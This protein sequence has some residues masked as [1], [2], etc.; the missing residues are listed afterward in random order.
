MKKHYMVAAVRASIA[1]FFIIILSFQNGSAQNCPPNN[2]MP[3]FE[4]FT[5]TQ[6]NSWNTSAYQSW[7][8]HK[9]D[10]PEAADYMRFRMLVPNG[11]NRCNNDGQKYPLIVFLHGSGES[12]PYD[13]NLNSGTEQNND[14]QLV[15]GGQQHRDAVANGTFPGFVIFPQIR[16][17][18]NNNNYWGIDNLHA[19]KYIIDKLI[20]DFKVDPD[21]VYMHGL[22]MGGEGT[23]I[24]LQN[25]PQTI[26]A[27]HPMSAA[28]SNFWNGATANR[29]TYRHIPLRHAQGGLDN[30]PTK[31]QGNEQVQKIREVGGNIRYD[32]FPT[33]GHGTWNSEYAKSDF[34]SW[35]LARRKN[36]IT[37]LGERT[38]FCPGEPFSVTLGLTAGFANYE[39]TKDNTANTPFASGPG[40]NEVTITDVVAAG[41]GVGT[42][43]ARFQ[44]ANGTWTAWSAGIVITT[45]QGP[46]ATPSI[47]SNGQ[48]VNLP[49]LDGSP[50]VTLTGT[51]NKTGYTW[52]RDVTALPNSTQSITVGTAGS[53]TLRSR[54]LPA[55]GFE[56]DGVTPTEFIGNP[57]GC[58]SSS[59]APVVVT[60]Q[61]GLGV[62]ATPTNFFASSTSPTSVTINW[63]DR[64]NNELGFEL[65]RSVISG[66]SYELVT[67]IPAKT[68]SNPQSYIDNN[69]S[70]N[71]T[72][73]YRMRA[74]NNSG[75]SAYT[76]QVQVTTTLDNQAPTAPV[77]TVG[78]TSRSEI[79]LSWTGATDNVGIFEYDLYQNNI[80]IA[81]TTTTSYKVTNLIAF[82]T[83]SYIVK[84]RDFVGNVSPPSNQVN[85]AAVN[86][87]LFYSYY[88]HP[89]NLSTVD[90]I[91]TS[92]TLIKTGYIAQF[93]LDP[94]TQ[95]DGFAFIYEGF[96]NIPT[97]GSYTFYTSSDD[98][99][100]LYVNN[101]L[102]V[103]N[104]GTHGCSE[105]ASSVISLSAGTYPV[106]AMMF[107][108]GGGECLTVSWQGPGISKAEIPASALR[109]N[110]TPP[111]AL[112]TPNNFSASAASF[113]QINISWSD[114][115]NNETG[116]E[117]SRSSSTNGTYQVIAVTAA[118]ATSYQHTG[119]SPSS[120][121]YY[122]IR[123]INATSASALVGPVNAT[124][125]NGP[126]S[127]SAPS[128][129]NATAPSPTQVNLTW[130][131]NSTSETGYEIQKSSSSS[132]GFVTFVT[133]AANVNS[134]SDTQ[135]NGHSTIYYRVRAIRTGANPSSY[136]NTASVTTPNRAPTIPNIP[137]QTMQASLG[138][139]QT[140]NVTV[141][142]LDSDPISFNI[143]GLPA[144]GSFNS[145]GY[146]VGT[147]S[148]TNVAAGVYVI[149]VQGS[150]GLASASDAFTLTFGSN[151]SPVVTPPPGFTGSLVTEEG[152]ITTLVLDVLDPNGN[153]IANPLASITNLPS[154]ATPAPTWNGTTRKLTFSFS[155]DVGQAGIYDNISVTFSDGVGGLTTYSFSVIV[156]PI[157][158]YFTMSFNVLNGFTPSPQTTPPYIPSNYFESAPWNNITDNATF[159]NLLDDQKNII[160]FVSLYTG[161]WVD[162]NPRAIDLPFSAGAVYTEKVRESFLKRGGGSGQTGVITFSNLNPRMVYQATV[163]GAG[164]A[165]AATQAKYV[166][167]NGTV[168]APKVVIANALNTDVAKTT[169]FIPCPNGTLTLTTSRNDGVTTGNVYLNAVILTG[170]YD[171]GSA[172]ELPT[173]L[174]LSAPAHNTVIVSWVDNS[175]NETSFEVLRA[176]A[177]AGPF[178]VV[179][180]KSPNDTS[181]VNNVDVFGRTSYYYKI[182]A[183]NDGVCAETAPKLI[184]TPNGIPVLQNLSTIVMQA[185]Q[186]FQQ[187]ISATDPENDPI[188]LTALNLPLFATLVD[189]GDGT[190]FIRFI[191]QSSDIG[192]YNFTVQ[193]TDN[194][195]ARAETGGSLVVQ[196]AQYL[197]V[198]YL[199]FTGT[200]T[201]SNAASPWNNISNLANA[202]TLINSAG[203]ESAIDLFVGTG[204]TA[205]SNTAGVSTGNNAG[206]YPDKILSS[207]WETTQTDPSSG[208]LITLSGLLPGNRYNLT[209]LG[210]RNQFWF[211][212]TIYTVTGA[213]A[214]TKALNTSKNKSNT[215]K[216]SGITP[217]AQGEITIRVKRAAD[218]NASPVVSHLPASLNAMI[219]E[220]AVPGPNPLKPGN[221]KAEGISKSAIKLSWTDNSSDET[222]FE[223][224]RATA[225]GGPYTLIHTTAANVETF[226]NSGLAQNAPFIYR[227]RAIK[228]SG[229]SVYTNDAYASTFDQIILVNVN[230]SPASGQLQASAPWNNLATPP[231]AGISFGPFKNDLNTTTT[232][233]MQMINWEIGGSNNTGFLTGNNSGVYPDAVLEAYYYYEQSDP[234][235]NHKLTGLAA[236]RVYDL[237]FMGNEW[238]TIAT[239]GGHIVATDYSVGTETVSQFNGKNTT[240]TVS[241]RNIQPNQANEIEFQVK[242]ND[243]ARYGVWNS[244]EIRS[245]TPLNAIFD[246]VPPTIPKNLIATDT[247]DVSVDL[248]WLASTDNAGVAGYEVFQGSTLV[249]TVTTVTAQVIGLQPSTV[250][251]FT[252]RAFDVKGNRSPFATPIQITTKP[253]SATVIFYYPK[254]TGSLSTLSTWGRNT[255]GTGTLPGNFI[256]NNQHFVLTRDA[257]LSSSFGVTGSNSKLIIDN[258]RTITIDAPLTGNVDLRDNA[259]AI[260]NTSTV[261]AFG[262]LSPTSTVVFNSVSSSVPGAI[263]GNVELEGSNSTKTLST[264]TYTING[265]LTVGNGITVNGATGNSTVI[266]LS[267][268]L[269][270]EGT[271][272]MNTSDQRIGLRLTSGGAQTIN[273]PQQDINL[274]Q[275]HLDKNTQLN[276]SSSSPRIIT[277]GTSNKGGLVLDSGA[278]FNLAAHHLVIEGTGTINEANNPT[279]FIKTSKGNITINSNNQVSNLYFQAGADTIKNFSLNSSLG[280]VHIRTKLNVQQKLDIANGAVNSNGNIV[281]LSD[282]N[283][284][285]W[286]GPI[287]NT[288]SLN[289]NIEFQRYFSPNGRVYRYVSAPVIGSTVAN[290]NTYLP[291]TGPF[292][293]SANSNTS[294]SLF[295]YD[296]ENGWVGYPSANS[297]EQISV[298]RGY[299]IFIFSGASARKLRINGP[300]QQ[301]DFVFNNLGDDATPESSE[302][303]VLPQNGWNLLGNPYAAPVQWGNGGWQTN[304]LNGSVYVRHN[305]I[306][307]GSLVSVVRVHNGTIGTLPNGIIAQGQSF[308]V[309]AIG[310]GS[311][312][313]TITEDAKYDTLSTILQRTATPRN[314]IEISLTKGKLSD[315][316]IIHFRESST[317]G[318]DDAFDA[319]KLANNYFNLSSRADQ[320]NLAI[321]T[322][323]LNFC[324]R[325]VPLNLTNTTLGQYAFTFGKLDSFSEP[326]VITLL[327]HYTGTST[328]LSEGSTL[329][330]EITGDVA[331]S[332]SNRFDVIFSKPALDKTVSFANPSETFCGEGTL[333]IEL[334]NSQPGVNY[335]LLLDDTELA[336]AEGNGDQ[337]LFNLSSDMVPEGSSQLHLVASFDGCTPE[338]IDPTLSV[339]RNVK[340]IVAVAANQLQ[341][342]GSGDLQWYLDGNPIAGAT[343]N[344]FHPEHAG[345]YKVQASNGLCSLMSDP[346]LFAVTAIENDPS[347][348]ELFPNPVKTRLT[349]RLGSSIRTGENVDIQIV[350]LQGMIV[351]KYYI[352][353]QKDGLRLPVADLRAGLYTLLIKAGNQQFEQRFIK[354]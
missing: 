81:T 42:Y 153:T 110:Y 280:Q 243:G 92:G 170:F 36:R 49:G 58:L 206:I 26:A 148:F 318:V 338:V 161:L 174:T 239:I 275:L 250:Y 8:Y 143:T 229:A 115:S 326:V 136:S 216:F 120:T 39:W 24:F 122:K 211:A 313:L 203:Q 335:T 254:P 30:A 89:A 105:K 173:N 9:P 353:N 344:V 2:T 301:G 41:S 225:Q 294:Y 160:R 124:T 347:A 346:V 88:H 266:N 317:E 19:V 232:V 116:F 337:M 132:T 109:D 319:L 182:R 302:D 227:I 255:D 241:I 329:A 316:A 118:N 249:A 146:G 244:L 152:R 257:T 40:A 70:A 341:S 127:P 260:I 94:R 11:F 193:A 164:P 149:N 264:G 43:Y 295:Y 340:P 151:Q 261:P 259:T 158:P 315:H 351:G 352:Q 187:N 29:L 93:K 207:L 210:S 65:Y 293:G 322:L 85:P 217:N 246:Q 265:N 133:T 299:S 103:N 63:D 108:D 312:S 113:S 106:K 310:E 230:S 126:N 283:G 278:V 86:T 324:N 138:T 57:L 185:G 273:T 100:R 77:L 245:Y 112:T 31:I 107:E 71:T 48:S 179:G 74:V 296:N 147:F 60:T 51:S 46:S 339:Q 226:T 155:P 297:Q 248:E 169:D 131:D 178:N 69:L 222:G 334:N 61:N 15:H 235:I 22:S 331:S 328:V 177:L 289:G 258:N 330:F 238:S 172:P 142:D 285:A 130:N 186:I 114:R 144:G 323:P 171:D 38:A 163:Y 287:R 198:V 184:T 263:Y 79:N 276:I 269:I 129:L 55:T 183:C 181:F 189:N 209:L 76:P 311:P 123:A 35:F 87:G 166:L 17:S 213:S 59:S 175:Y 135:V 256:S 32:Y 21:R 305:E 50:E 56:A 288:G 14:Y 119:L 72:Y 327:D 25:F 304:G 219:I 221:F 47:S 231:S 1:T 270:F 290:W 54:D 154:F 224:Y 194:F 262:T 284:S 68:T 333:Q 5:Y 215:V 80:L 82:T 291:V 267:G 271:A 321:N 44:R 277:L 125:Q 223:I 10:A 274:F 165:S 195:S 349:I 121:H 64:A 78:A 202:T 281:L 99:S 23:W 279:S 191:P 83:Y 192:S 298:G 303:D 104:D 320:T 345:E 159:T 145:N 12:A 314:L 101:A 13:A 53:Y 52:T 188:V 84:A 336:E 242:Q 251:T 201:S 157:D 67:I 247:T 3:E 139:A 292:S 268:N 91:T 73:Y 66:S 134:F 176:T 350:N 190:G 306:V 205:S 16:R 214:T 309:K 236:N 156:I 200:G 150:D 308:W 180:T 286:I 102:V 90:Q 220:V 128:S 252:V 62:P 300:I 97:T 208:A 117:I 18:S 141:S 37:V 212:K 332:A 6:V 95:N 307:D 167:S 325:T 272:A 218:E 111:A 140:L 282:A 34:F 28:G 196:D 33:L 204:W 199:N 4:P 75:G 197:E 354:E 168:S 228:A 96:I 233:G 343:S 348:F 162:G 237:V 253:S 137:D 45:S 20:A 27:A 342:T 98:G 240:E 234:A 7:Q